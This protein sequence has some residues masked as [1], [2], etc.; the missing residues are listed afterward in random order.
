MEDPDE[1]LFPSRDLVLVALREDKSQYRIPF[2]ALGDLPLDL[3]YGSAIET[4]VS[5]LPAIPCRQPGLPSQIPN[6]IQDGPGESI[7]LS[8]LQSPIE[9]LTYITAH[10]PKVDVILIVG[11]RVLHRC[12]LEG[13]FRRVGRDVRESW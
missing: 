8:P 3:R 10:P 4:S 12:E 7:L 11:H 6:R 2:T 9:Y 13:C 1:V 5:G